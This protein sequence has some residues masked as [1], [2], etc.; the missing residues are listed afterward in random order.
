[1]VVVV[2]LQNEFIEV[3]IPVKRRNLFCLQIVWKSEI[4]L[5][6][7]RMMEFL[8]FCSIYDSNFWTADKISSA[9]SNLSSSKL[10]SVVAATGLA[11]TG[12]GFLF[13]SANLVLASAIKASFLAKSLASSAF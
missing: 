10:I 11:T 2:C 7:K 1:M 9:K 4:N 8:A 6:Q 12:S 5:K 3:Y 13:N